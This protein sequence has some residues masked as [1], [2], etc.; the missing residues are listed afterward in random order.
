LVN[1]RPKINCKEELDSYLI[2]LGA[3]GSLPARGEKG[4]E[5]RHG[6]E[7]IPPKGYFIDVSAG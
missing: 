6:K 5:A 2:P 7:H 3:A 4:E 1:K